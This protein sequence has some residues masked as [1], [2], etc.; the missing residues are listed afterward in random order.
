M[1]RTVQWTK[2]VAWVLALIG[3]IGL[4]LHFWQQDFDVYEQAPQWA[5][6]AMHVWDTTNCARL[7]LIQPWM[8]TRDYSTQETFASKLAGYFEAAHRQGALTAGSVVVLPEHLG[9]WLVA[10]DEWPVVYAT[11]KLHTAM[12]WI[13]ATNLLEL[14]SAFRQM[15]PAPQPIRAALFHMKAQQMHKAYVQTFTDLACQYG[16]YILAGSI[17]LPDS[18]LQGQLINAAMYFTPAGQYG[19]SGKKA[20]PTA[21]EQTFCTAAPIGAVQPILWPDAAATLAHLICADA[22]Y[23]QVYQNLQAQTP[24]W[25]VVSA[26]IAGDSLWAQPWSGYDGFAAPSDVD[27]TDIGVLT[28]RQAWEKYALEGRLHQSG[29]SCG[30]MVV[31][32]GRLWDLGADGRSF[33]MKNGQYLTSTT[34]DSACI[35][36]T[37]LSCR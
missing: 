22:W 6:G 26:F 16:V 11:R 35:L 18:S 8:E 25:I 12:T 4:E 34:C 14:L 32:R 29:A 3:A 2:R 23:P 24:D 28:E 17:V 1:G 5:L 10:I 27:L 7:V 20:F 30:A 36:A 37:C 19:W 21:D 15:P 33:I 31:L 13:I 9:T